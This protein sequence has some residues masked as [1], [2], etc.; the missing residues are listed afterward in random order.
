MLG[1]DGVA[2]SVCFTP[3]CSFWRKSQTLPLDDLMYKLHN[4]HLYGVCKVIKSSCNDNKAGCRGQ[5]CINNRRPLF[6]NIIL[7][8]RVLTTALTIIITKHRLAIGP[9]G[10]ISYIGQDI[11][12]SWQFPYITCTGCYLYNKEHSADDTIDY[13]TQIGLFYQWL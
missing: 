7:L 13:Y 3:G 8:W 1:L 5:R 2:W 11:F 12:H 6:S 4:V 10:N 9:R